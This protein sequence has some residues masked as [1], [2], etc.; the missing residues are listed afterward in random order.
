MSTLDPTVASVFDQHA[1]AEDDEEALIASLEEDGPLDAF[2][3]Q[4][5][6]QLHAEF[7]RAKTIKEQ[8]GGSFLEITEE[9]ELL[10]I[11]TSTRL[12]VVHFFKPDF[13][14]CT[15]MDTKLELLAPRHFDTRLLR[16]NVDNAPFLVT[17]LKIQVLPCV[18]A[19][20]DGIGVDRI[21]GFEGLGK[22]DTFSVRDLENRLL[23]S[24]VLVRSKTSKDDD[25]ALGHIR[26]TK[27]SNDY[28]DDDEDDWD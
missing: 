28:D 2:R 3:E 26:K 1:S 7:S 15:V 5:L 8:G 6:Q 14:R 19:F 24:G 21:I 25:T 12:C 4:R 16:I 10:D 27:T 20:I 18:I 11:T 9:K 17:K 13:G 23:R 22:G